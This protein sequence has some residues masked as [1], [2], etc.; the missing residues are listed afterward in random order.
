M[1]ILKRT[2]LKFL[3]V[4]KYTL[5]KENILQNKRRGFLTQS[6]YY[7]NKIAQVKK[8]LNVMV[9]ASPPGSQLPPPPNQFT[10]APGQE[11]S[12]AAF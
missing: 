6:I 9:E 10:T 12:L 7:W 8:N 2:G 3:N 5:N 1:I 11:R 4:P